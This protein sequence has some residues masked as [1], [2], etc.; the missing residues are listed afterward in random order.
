MRNHLIQCPTALSTYPLKAWETFRSDKLLVLLSYTGQ[1]KK[2]VTISHVYKE[3]TSEPTITRYASILR[4]ALKVWYVT[5]QILN[6]GTPCHTAHINLIVHFCPDYLR[7]V[8]VYGCLS[9]DEALSQFLKII[10][11]GWYVDDVLDIPPA[12]AQL[13]QSWSSQTAGYRTP[14][15]VES[16]FCS[17]V[18]PG[19]GG[20]K[21]FPA[22]ITNKLWE[23]SWQ[24]LYIAWLEA[25]W[26]LNYKHVKVLPSFFELPCI[27]VRQRKLIC[28][29]CIT[30]S[31]WNISLPC[32]YIVGFVIGQIRKLK[33]L[34]R[35]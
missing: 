8:P 6:V 30:R 23:F 5:L 16:P 15:A 22:S 7:H 27:L 4:K 29:W 20:P 32:L 33:L 19:G 12:L 31:V 25:H 28:F 11:Q 14:F 35:D 2:K 24:L 1:F 21:H 17:T 10:R 26:L 13:L 34:I 3:V 9:G 18:S